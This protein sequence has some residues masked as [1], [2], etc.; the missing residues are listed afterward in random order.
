MGVMIIPFVS[1]L[2]DDVINAVPQ[3]LRDGA[4]A[5][6]ATQ[7]ETIKQVVLPAALPGII[8]AILLAVS[9][10]IGETMIV[11]MAAGGRALITLDPSSDITTVTYQIV[12]LLTGDTAFDSARTVSAFALG[13]VLFGVTLLFNIIAL[14][15]VQRYREAYD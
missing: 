15:V 14:R 5:V 4:L 6:G 9:R 7:S 10:A 13:F 11:V 2:S 12:S 3:P 1:S 8:A